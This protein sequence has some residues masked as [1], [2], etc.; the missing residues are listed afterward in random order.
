MR[1]MFQFFFS[2]AEN[3]SE[4]GTG[5]TIA[6]PEFPCQQGPDQVYQCLSDCNI[7]PFSTH[8]QSR[9]QNLLKMKFRQNI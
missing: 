3:Q 2:V 6:L 8:L 7:L 9:I 4:G 1:T 5:P